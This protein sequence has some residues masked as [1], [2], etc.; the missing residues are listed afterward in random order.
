MYNKY[1]TVT[2]VMKGNWSNYD[3]YLKEADCQIK[4]E[5]D[6]NISAMF[7]PLLNTVDSK[8]YK[9]I[10]YKNNMHH[11]NGC[12]MYMN[13]LLDDNEVF[14]FIIESIESMKNIKLT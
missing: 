9:Y 3:N 14:D 1:T 8:Y 6:A 13:R 12:V 4:V 7:D 5:E 2:E 11:Y 10:V